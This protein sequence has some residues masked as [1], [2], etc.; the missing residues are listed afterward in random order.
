[1]ITRDRAPEALATLRRLRALPERPPLVVVDNGSTD[2]TAA[3]VLAAFPDVR[4]EAL[5]ENLGCAG[6]TVGVR[7]ATTPYVAFSDDDSWWAAGALA[8][9]EAH[10]DA[11]ARLGVLAARILVGVEERDDPLNAVLARSPLE[12]AGA[13][14]GP[15]LL[16][17]VACGA[18]VRRDAYLAAGGFDARYGV[19]GEEALLAIELARRGWDLAYCVD[20]VAHHHPSA[21]R[22]PVG[23]RRREVRNDL[24]TAWL[25]RRP[26]TVLRRTGGVALRALRE[27]AARGGLRDAA[28]DL[29]WVLRERAPVD[30]GLEA[31]LRLVDA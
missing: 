27:P 22:D 24:V 6:R 11:H 20:V 13:L 16:G 25:R 21:V 1:M 14:P 7:V 3:R 18:V 2:G 19:G 17:F 8:R 29:T 30:R 26:G 10:L 31:R 12:A 15:P 28:R 4:V 23:R 5:E 9:A